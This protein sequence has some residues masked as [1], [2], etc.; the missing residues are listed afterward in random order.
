MEK[1]VVEGNLELVKALTSGSLN[2]DYLNS[3]GESMLHVACTHRQLDIVEFLVTGRYCN[4]AVQNHTGQTALHIACRSGCLDTVKL[5]SSKCDVNMQTVDGDTPLHIACQHCHIDIA[6]FLTEVRGSNPSIANSQGDLALHIACKQNSVALV[7]TVSDCDVNTRTRT[8]TGNTPVHITLTQRMTH[9]NIDGK[10]S[11]QIVQ[12]LVNEKHCDLSLPDEHGWLPLHIACKYDSLAIVKLCSNCDVNAGSQEGD[13]PL[14]IALKRLQEKHAAMEGHQIVQYLVNEKHCD[15]SLPDEHGWLPLHIACKYGSLAI[16]KLCSNCD[17]NARSQEGDTP[18]H[19]ALKRLQEKHAAMEGHQI[20]EYLV[21]EMHCDVSLPD[22]DGQLPVHIACAQDSP[23]VVA[24]VSM[25]D[26]NVQTK[27]GNTPLHIAL[28]ARR[29]F[30]VK[31]IDENEQI[32]K[33]LV[34]EKKCDLSLLNKNGC[35]PLHIACQ[36]DSLALV[37]LVSNCNVNTT[38]QNGDTPIHTIIQQIKDQEEYKLI[39]I[40]EYL[41]NEKHCDLSVPNKCGNLPL[42]VACQHNSLALV[43]LVSNCSVN[44]ADKN[45]NTPLHIA[46]KEISPKKGYEIVQYLVTEKHCDLTL[47]NENGF[48]P[49]HIACQRGSLPLVELVSCCDVNTRT[50]YGATP[51]NIVL[52][53]KNVTKLNLL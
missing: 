33:Y 31:S 39:Q 28:L 32:V 45:G 38:T 26:I 30:D 1:A 40:V 44:T 22:K 47:P 27:D 12:Y 29:H 49:L 42:H 46:L 25:C 16:V 14:H 51:L 3:S 17:V 50:K 36:Y 18:L 4:Q 41:V 10:E 19:I 6:K 15:L 20:V 34:N 2:V 8:N 9:S 11:E 13:T 37:E 52:N 48:I 24:L 21:N 53:G 7:T 5:V 43:K 23:A 35:L